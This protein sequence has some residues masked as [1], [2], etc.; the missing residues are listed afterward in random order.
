MGFN[1][2]NKISD[3]DIPAWS[4]KIRYFLGDQTSHLNLHLIEGILLF[5]SGQTFHTLG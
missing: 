2:T 1:I 4:P 5:Y 3:K